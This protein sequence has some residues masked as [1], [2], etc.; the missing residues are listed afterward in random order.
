MRQAKNAGKISSNEA[1]TTQNPQWSATRSSG[2]R[3]DYVDDLPTAVKGNQQN[4]QTEREQH[5]DMFQDKQARAM[6][7]SAGESVDMTG[8]MRASFNSGCVFLFRE[9][10]VPEWSRQLRRADLRQF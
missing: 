3:E 8:Q 9:S 7:G 1:A 5:T 6:S 10:E 4:K 2:F